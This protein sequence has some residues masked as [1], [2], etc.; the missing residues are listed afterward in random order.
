MTD[1]PSQ[2]CKE[3][4]YLHFVYKIES[5]LM[6]LIQKSEFSFFLV[7]SITNVGYDILDDVRVKAF[8]THVHQYIE[9]TQGIFILKIK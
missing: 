4:H 1:Q 7:R 3:K 2:I 8:L 5:Q 6:E 9:L